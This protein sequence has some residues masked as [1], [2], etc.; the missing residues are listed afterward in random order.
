M[1]HLLLAWKLRST[2]LN[3][4]IGT[5][6]TKILFLVWIKLAHIIHLLLFYVILIV[7]IIEIPPFL[8]SVIRIFTFIRIFNIRRNLIINGYIIFKFFICIILNIPE[9]RRYFFLNLMLFIDFILLGPYLGK[10]IVGNVTQKLVIILLLIRRIFIIGERLL[11]GLIFLLIWLGL[12]ICLLF[13][14]SAN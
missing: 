7:S 13:P 14:S 10:M 2:T 5:I 8:I 4:K 12:H 6:F 1:A 3:I 9:L 11:V